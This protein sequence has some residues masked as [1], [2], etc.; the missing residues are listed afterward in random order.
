MQ[1][2]LP[3]VGVG[4]KN[5]KIKIK[6]VVWVKTVMVVEDCHVVACVLERSLDVT[7]EADR[8]HTPLFNCQVYAVASAVFYTEPA[9]ICPMTRLAYH[10]T[11]RA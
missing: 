2:A 1:L 8:P 9:G 7:A 4:E 3:R 6:V 5:K 10:D 11:T